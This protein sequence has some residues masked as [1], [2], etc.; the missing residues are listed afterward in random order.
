MTRLGGRHHPNSLDCAI[1]G[2]RFI[3]ND[4]KF[5]SQ[6]RAANH[7]NYVFLCATWRQSIKLDFCFYPHCS[8]PFPQTRSASPC[9]QIEEKNRGKRLYPLLSHQDKSVYLVQPFQSAIHQ[10]K[11]QVPWIQWQST[12]QVQYQRVTHGFGNKRPNT[13]MWRTFSKNVG[14]AITVQLTRHKPI[15]NEPQSICEDAHGAVEEGHISTT[16]TKQTK[17][18][19]YSA[20]SMKSPI[21]PEV[22]RKLIVE[23]IIDRQ[24]AFNEVEAQSFRNMI[25]YM[26]KTV[27]NFLPRSGNTIRTDTLKYF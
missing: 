27:V 8:N 16:E 17:L 3:S 2:I 15:C 20:G 21:R 11:V 18:E 13:V 6:S 25:T 12:H 5:V 14:P 26:N 7:A 9:L 24:H 10:V 4:C 23:W 22:L 19:S 1:R